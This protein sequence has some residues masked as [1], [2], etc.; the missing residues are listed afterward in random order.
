MNEYELYTRIIHP[1]YKSEYQNRLTEE[2]LR[3]P[4]TAQ[5]IDTGVD[6][7][8]L[9][10]FDL[11]DKNFLP[12]FNNTHVGREERV[13]YPA[14]DKLLKFC[15]YIMLVSKGGKLYVLL[16]EMKSGGNAE[17]SIQ[18]KAAETFMEY[19]K[20][21]ALRIKSYNGYDSFTAGNI[22]LRRVLLK[23]LKSKPTTNVRNRQIDT[24]GDP[25]VCRENIFPIMRIC[26]IHQR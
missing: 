14:P 1:D 16:I 15:D 21:T 24:S 10:R 17:A 19:I 12:F 20:Q 2:K 9:Y 22:I 5:I 26:N 23:P 4:Q 8:I 7:Y 25:I 18:L 11:D 6:D 3:R 13:E